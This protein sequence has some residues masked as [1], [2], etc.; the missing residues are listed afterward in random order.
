MMIFGSFKKVGGETPVNTTTANVQNRP[1]VAPLAGGGYVVVW[2]SRYDDTRPFGIELRGQVFG[3]DGER[4]GAEFPVGAG[5][6]PHTALNPTVAALPGGGF[7]VAWGKTYGGDP[8]TG[9]DIAA[10]MYD[11]AGNEVG[12]RSEVASRSAF[13]A[14]APSVTMLADGGFVVAWYDDDTSAQ[15]RA[16]IVKAQLFDSSGAKVGAEFAPG[17]TTLFQGRADVAALAG[18][19]F[20]VTWSA[21]NADG[22]GAGILYRVYDGG[23]TAVGAATLA[24]ARTGRDQDLVSAAPLSTGG[25]VLTWWDDSP[26]AD[27]SASGIRAQLFDA[28]GAKLGPEFVVNAT[29]AGIQRA[30]SVHSHPGGFVIAWEDHGGAGSGDTSGAAVRAQ[31]F[32]TGG[33]KVGAEFLVNTTTALNQV[34]PA[35]AALASGAI[36]VA[37]TDDSN[38]TATS[39]DIRTQVFA[40]GTVQGTNGSDVM[41]LVH[42]LDVNVSGF[43]GVDSFY[44]GAAFTAGDTVNGGGNRDSIIL[45]GDYSSGVTFGTGSVSNIAGIES[46]SLLSGANASYGDGAGN[47][48]SYRLTML[49]SNVAAGALMKVNGFHLRAGEDFTFDASAESDAA[50]QVFAGLGTDDLTGGGLG[51]AFIFGHDGRFA[52]GDR[53]D[54]GGG[55]DVVYLR[56]DYRLDFNA[57]GF[58]G[59]F[60][61]VESI[62]ILTSA[63]NEFAGGGDG[64]FDYDLVWA[65]ALLA[66]GA[67]FTVNASRLQAHETFDFD[68]SRE[69]N[70]HLRLFG[71]AAADMLTGGAGADQLHGGGGADLLAG[72]AGADLFRFSRTS[73]STD[74]ETDTI[75]CFV[76]GID[77]IDLNRVDAK[78]GTAEENEAFAFIGAGAFSASGPNAPGEL[79]AFNVSGKL[80]RVEGDVNGDGVADLVIHVQVE[81]GQPLSE[82]DF[83]L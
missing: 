23:G 36:A 78:A 9:Q 34:E 71:G 43:G 39:T 30:P 40:P 6:A 45:Q 7:I 8:D 41:R 2:N 10:Q 15:P 70:G 68:G 52:K 77:R 47:F 64:E 5:P 21:V 66:S 24:N 12:S 50:V 42:A 49:D 81:A 57:A 16:R 19:G 67:T 79:R 1:T 22:D 27:G 63:N 54:G 17:G 13:N 53:V 32:D 37:W 25:F 51:D 73:D 75:Q 33:N 69:T 62:A 80:W 4:I 76:S 82:G 11:A 35:I 48:Y 72:G 59:A 61:N 26:G 31:L 3:A 60:T 14:L 55:Y 56:G 18:G 29:V 46:I 65:D 44:F 28:A 74:A 83:V 20:V 38:S 58:E